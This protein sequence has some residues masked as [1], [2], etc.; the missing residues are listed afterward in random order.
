MRATAE[1]GALHPLLHRASQ[2]ELPPW[3]EAGPDRRAHIQ[4]VVALL[5]EWGRVLDLPEGERVRWLAAGTLHDALRDAD[6]GTLR[7]EVPPALRDLPG[8]LLHGPAVA[9]RLRAEGV[10]DEGLLRAVA[11]HTLGHG[12]LDGVGRA[13]YAADF[14][15]PGR[16]FRRGWRRGLATRYPHAP[17]EVLVE[18]VRAR[19]VRLLERGWTLRPETVEFWNTLVGG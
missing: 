17:D 12:A 5:R 18:V 6:P 3:S 10:S 7:D 1:N 9:A 11:F 16:T 4:R 14:L 8:S 13:L 19:M 15:E 2:G